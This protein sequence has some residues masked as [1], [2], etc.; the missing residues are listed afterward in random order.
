MELNI[1][2]SEI[3]AKG[4][5]ALEE[6]AE[7]RG[8]M[9]DV[10]LAVITL[11]SFKFPGL[12]IRET[13]V[14]I[15]GFYDD[16]GEKVERISPLLRKA[17]EYYDELLA[18]P[19]A[20]LFALER[21]QTES[22]GVQGNKPTVSDVV[23]RGWFFEQLDALADFEHWSRAEYWTPDEAVAVSFGKNPNAVIK[24]LDNAFPAAQFCDAFLAA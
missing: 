11:V 5:T 17:K 10:D 9:N 4:K 23:N 24:A 16:V 14:V 13:G 20:D 1:N 3:E 22:K 2:D 6:E 15:H 7:L 19:S 18:L 21:E 12:S 8:L